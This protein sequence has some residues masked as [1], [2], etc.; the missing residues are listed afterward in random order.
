MTK[1]ATVRRLLD[2]HGTTFCEEIGIRIADNT[3]SAL[4]QWLTAC[5]LFSAP[6]GHRQAVRAAVALSK[7]GY[8]TSRR[9]ADATWE[10]RVKVLNEN[11]YARFD[12]RTARILQDAADL[13]EEEY[14]GDLRRL[15]EAAG[16]DPAEER[17]RLK[18][19]KGIGDVGVDIFAR[20]AQAVWPE[21]YPFAD[22]LALKA[23]ERHGL[24]KDAEALS[25]AIPREDF[26]RLVAALVRD[27]LGE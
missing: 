17:R 5:I 13:V 24:G 23:A 16:R 19:V 18:A 15:R 25:R 10:E 1:D 20:E 2:E 11:G 27:E 14:K 7:A 3:P 12:E 21:L 4:F 26:P 9:M 8:R 6:I 22:R